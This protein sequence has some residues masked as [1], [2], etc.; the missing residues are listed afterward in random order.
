MFRASVDPSSKYLLETRGE[1][2]N[3]SNY[4]GSD[5]FLTRVSYTEDWNRAKRLGDAYYENQLITRALNE[6]LGTSFLNNRSGT[7][8]VQSMLDNAVTEQKRLGLEVGKE[9]T[10]EQIENLKEDIVW[11]VETEV[12]GQKVLAPQ[13][14]L[15]SKSRNSLEKDDRDRIGGIEY[16]EIKTKD[17]ENKGVKLGNKG[18]TIVEAD[19]VRNESISDRLSDIT[20]D[21]TIVESKGNIE[22]I[23]GRIAGNEVAV[24]KS[25]T[26]DI[27]NKGQKLGTE[28]NNGEYDRTRYE[29]VGNVGLIQG[30][31]VILDAGK[32][33]SEGGVLLSKELETDVD[34]MEIRSQELV[35]SDK[36][37]TGGK[38]YRTFTS[39]EYVGSAVISER[40]SGRIGDLNIEGSVFEVED[41]KGL[42]IGSVRVESSVNEYDEFS[43]NENRNTT[44]KS[45]RK[46]ESHSEEN[47]A[48]TFRVSDATI[49]G[50]VTGI[51]SNIDL[52]EDTYVGGKITTDSRQLH[53]SYYEENK[54]SG[55]S[56]SI[57]GGS[58]SLG[59][60]KSRNTY[61]EKSLINARSSL[62]IGDGSTL[63]NGAEITATN[64]VHGNIQINNGDVTYGARKDTVDIKT[65]S[66]SSNFGVSIGIKSPILDRIE[67]LRSTASQ[68]R[69]GDTLGGGVN[70]V[71]FV[72]GT[73]SGLASNQ[74]NRQT[75]HDS[76]CLQIN[77]KN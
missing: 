40:A 16:T 32:Y 12:N 50:S 5:Y 71:N 19:T 53:N 34:R 43:L 45:S 13:V 1:Y 15:S 31:K 20:G 4:L 57:S 11:Y 18:I 55:F 74:G 41:G 67:Q 21:M 28:I 76:N 54:R 3:L 49:H 69:N 38:N 36:L 22:N 25:E 39:K 47:V 51:G 27:L 29:Q 68:V 61:D 35:G 24:L 62:M 46:T 30:N 17:L 26:G 65:T 73:I 70:A 42:D 14:Y 72:T 9:L 77:W 56:G 60:G 8:L 2:V 52:G 6:K 75:K 59:Y 44:S 37:G 7:E 66:K 10:K 58:V 23:G 64:F 63:N 48:G 33:T